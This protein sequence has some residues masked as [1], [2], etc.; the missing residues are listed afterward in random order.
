MVLRI[1]INCEGRFSDY[2]SVRVRRHIGAK[3]IEWEQLSKAVL[4]SWN[5]IL[6]LYPEFALSL[7]KTRDYALA[8]WHFRLGKIYLKNYRLP[9]ARREFIACT[10]LSKGFSKALIYAVI[11]YFGK[12]SY[13]LLIKS[14]NL[15]LMVRSR[16]FRR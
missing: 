6:N 2:P 7:G 16:M 12:T 11:L 14:L 3:S 10:R 13:C 5:K 9:E 1:A 15:I 8:K 4:H